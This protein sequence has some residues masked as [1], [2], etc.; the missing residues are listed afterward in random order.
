MVGAFGDVQK[1]ELQFQEGEVL[2]ILSPR[3]AHLSHS[4]WCDPQTFQLD[5][6]SL[7]LKNTSLGE[8]D[9]GKLLKECLDYC[10]HAWPSQETYD[11]LLS[12]LSLNP[13]SR[14]EPDP[15]DLSAIAFSDGSDCE[16]EVPPD[17]DSKVKVEQDLQPKL[18]V[19]SSALN[20]KLTSKQAKLVHMQRM[21]HRD[22][23][24]KRQ[25]DKA[26][27]AADL[28]CEVECNEGSGKYLDYTEEPSPDS[29]EDWSTSI[30]RKHRRE[31][32]LK[33]LKTEELKLL[34]S[35]FGKVMKEVERPVTSS[36]DKQP[37][38]PD[39]ATG[40]PG[41]TPKTTRNPNE[42]EKEELLPEVASIRHLNGSECRKLL[43]QMRPLVHAP[44]AIY[45]ALARRALDDYSKS[46]PRTF[47]DCRRMTFWQF[48]P[49]KERRRVDCYAGKA[50]FDFLTD[51]KE[52]LLSRLPEIHPIAAVYL[53]QTLLESRNVIASLFQEVGRYVAENI[54]T[55]DRDSLGRLVYVF[56]KAQVK[57]PGLFS[58]VKQECLRR[59]KFKEG[60]RSLSPKVITDI[61]V[62]F[63]SAKIVDEDLFEALM[64]R[65]V[66]LMDIDLQQELSPE[67]CAPLTS[68]SGKVPATPF[69]LQDLVQL[70]RSFLDLQRVDQ[71]FF[72][73]VSIY[74]VAALQSPNTK[75][76]D[77][78]VGNPTLTLPSMANIF[79]KARLFQSDFFSTLKMVATRRKEEIQP[80]GFQ[81]LQQALLTQRREEE[82]LERRK[83]QPP[84]RRRGAMGRA[85]VEPQA[86]I[87]T[88]SRR[89]KARQQRARLAAMSEE[90]VAKEVEESEKHAGLSASAKVLLSGFK[91]E[92][93][94]EAQEG[95]KEVK[96]TKSEVMEA[97][98]AISIRSLVKGK[99]ARNEEVSASAKAELRK[100]SRS[101]R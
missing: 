7:K 63:A 91:V 3:Q 27:V 65:A 42:S 30:T 50:F 90:E 68:F 1:L 41:P 8:N 24:K 83:R 69:L 96:R 40:D 44:L 34:R 54:S 29:N 74:V 94:L 64:L 77:W 80:E 85:V 100:H 79:V 98:T 88:L 33:K 72:N 11:S 57:N 43:Q 58:V 75:L 56:A 31:V 66:S 81:Q 86:A 2:E 37:R 9:S 4:D 22:I 38:E 15:T 59:C 36:M 70:C 45:K 101:R 13:D 14:A 73:D 49:E 12:K 92:A 17:S 47:H 51:E 71:E 62:A 26:E 87:S 16:S 39:F 60:E 21:L 5:A 18:T 10:S 97:S 23:E 93:I 19:Q 61:V 89:E 82:K 52:G 35:N 6:R 95:P 48:G 76:V 55:L 20:P 99:K 28:E 53:L 25:K 46:K 32:G 67:V 78:F 84:E